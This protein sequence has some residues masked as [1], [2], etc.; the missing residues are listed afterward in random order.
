V[1]PDLEAG[2]KVLAEHLAK[3]WGRRLARLA[4]VDTT[5]AAIAVA[6]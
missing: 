4:G 2:V 1:F 3:E 6:E 5:A